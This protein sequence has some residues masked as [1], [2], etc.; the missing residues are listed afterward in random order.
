MPCPYLD[1]S[2]LIILEEEYK[3]WSYAAFSNLLSLH[4]SLVQ[5]FS[6]TPKL[7]T[8]SWN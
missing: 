1:L 6:S 7:T 2:I 5:I 8:I 4:S 3:L